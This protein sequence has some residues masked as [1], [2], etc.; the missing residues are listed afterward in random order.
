MNT[1]AESSCANRA[2]WTHSPLCSYTVNVNRSELMVGNPK[3][4]EER[5][6]SKTRLTTQDN[7][8]VQRAGFE[9]ILLAEI[10]RDIRNND[11]ISV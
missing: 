6:V 3:N 9:R 2:A 11:L 5:L 1:S 8:K 4:M 7:L 10:E